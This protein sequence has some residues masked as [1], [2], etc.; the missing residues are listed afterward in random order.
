MFSATMNYKFSRPS[1]TL[2]SRR[3]KQILMLSGGEGVP[4]FI[5]AGKNLLQLIV[6]LFLFILPQIT[7][8][9]ISFEKNFGGS[10]VDVGAAVRP[11]SDGGFIIV[12]ETKSYGDGSYNVYL[13]KTNAS[14][15][16]LWTKKLGENIYIERGFSIQQTLDNGYIIT[17][18][19][20]SNRGVGGTPVVL[21]LK[22]D[23]AGIVTWDRK[24]GGNGADR[25]NSVQ[26]TTDGG[27]IIVGYTNSY[28]AGDSDVWLLKT[29][30]MFIPI[31]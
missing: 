27:Y 28:G 11:T 9:Q 1:S 20:Q 25:G 24:F 6:L 4:V 5:H 30:S 29:T 31:L 22:T 18:E 15:D 2:I 7:Y 10:A 8:A 13:I 23:A 3:Y 26:L 14:G 21:I 16:T 19:Y 12:G 17:G